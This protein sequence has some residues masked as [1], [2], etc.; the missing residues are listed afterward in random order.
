MVV[1]VASKRGGSVDG[2][3]EQRESER[4]VGYHGYEKPQQPARASA[5]DVDADDAR[6][7]T[8]SW[9]LSGGTKA[10]EQHTLL[11]AHSQPNALALSLSLFFSLCVNARARA[12]ANVRK[13]KYKDRLTL[14][15]FACVR[16][17]WQWKKV[18]GRKIKA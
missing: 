8:D 9:V 5:A 18:K 3:E 15:L 16:D 10:S 17:E 12:R 11:L 1:A 6:G 7:V 14:P 4:A 13:E 2:D